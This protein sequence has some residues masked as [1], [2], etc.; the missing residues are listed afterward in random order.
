MTTTTD[1]DSDLSIRHMIA[2]VRAGDREPLGNLLQRYESYLVTLATSQLN[3]RLWK[4]VSPLDVVQETLLAAHR[5]FGSFRGE[6]ESELKAWLRKILL[7]CLRQSI[8]THL[9]ASKRDIRREVSIDRLCDA[10]ELCGTLPEPMLADRG[11]SP[12]EPIRNHERL[13]RIADQLA[14]LRPDYREVI[15]YRNL[16]GMSFNEIAE[17]MDRKPGTVRM[18]W[19]RAVSQ[20]RQLYSDD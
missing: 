6:S 17:L 19:Q 7:N 10:M 18:L 3:R 1:A 2:S 8:D 9:R 5:D 20:F 13:V 15:V 11:P 4:R 14:K 12:S 16:R